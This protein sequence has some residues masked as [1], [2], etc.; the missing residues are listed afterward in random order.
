MAVRETAVPTSTAC[1]SNEGNRSSEENSIC[2]GK[3][4]CIARPASKQLPHKPSVQ[5][6]QHAANPF[7]P[8]DSQNAVNT[9]SQTGNPATQHQ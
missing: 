2:E 3:Q 8:T 1:R 9:G 5:A 4:Q 7:S 6:A